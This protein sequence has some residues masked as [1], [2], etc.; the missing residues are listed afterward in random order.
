MAETVTVHCHLP[1]AIAL[2]VDEMHDR[3]HGS[4]SINP[5]GV[6][7]AKRGEAVELRPG[8][9]EVDAEFWRAWSEQS[10]GTPLAGAFSAEEAAA[11]LPPPPCQCW[12]GCQL[13]V[14]LPPTRGITNSPNVL[15]GKNTHDERQIVSS[16][17][18]RAIL[19]KDIFLTLSLV[20]R[21]AD[22]KKTASGAIGKA[23]KHERSSSGMPHGYGAR[24][25]VSS[26]RS[27]IKMEGRR[28]R[29]THHVMPSTVASF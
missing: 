17:T 15:F 1:H 8:R 29:R 4:Y 3:E 21:L 23:I 28:H 9:N 26:G 12:L 14:A 18:I 5:T 20:L 11:A 19:P 2:H 10:K 6:P 7:T 24:G 13:P 16:L 25:D 27:P 22:A